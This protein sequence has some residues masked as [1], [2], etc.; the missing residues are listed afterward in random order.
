ADAANLTSFSSSFTLDAPVEDSDLDLTGVT[1]TANAKDITDGSQTG[2]GD[3]TTTIVVDAI[4]DE[5]PVVT[6]ALVPEVDESTSGSQTILLGLGFSMAD[7]GFTGSLAGGADTDGSEAVTSVTVSLSDGTLVL[8]AGYAGSASL[9]DNGGGNWTLSGWADAADLEAAV[10]ALSVTVAEGFDGTITGSISTTTQE[11]NT[12]EGAVAASG[13]E[14]DTSDNVVSDTFDFS[15]I[16]DSLPTAGNLDIAVDEDDLP[17]GNSDVATGD[18]LADP[19]PTIIMGTLN[20]DFGADS[21]GGSV[22]FA[23]LDGL[24]VVDTGSNPVT[25]GSVALVYDWNAGTNTLTALAGATPVFT[26]VVTDPSTGDFTFTLLE[27]VDHPTADTEDN[28]AIALAFTVT[29]GDGDMATGTLTVDIDDDSPNVVT[30]NSALLANDAGGDTATEQLNFFEIVG[31]DRGSDADVVFVNNAADNKL[32]GSFDGGAAE[33]LTAGGHEILLTGF[34]SASLQGFVDLNDNGLID[35]GAGSLVLQIDLNPDA[36]DESLDTYTIQ[37]FGMIDNG[38]QII[39]DDFSGIHGNNNVFFPLNSSNDPSA[40]EDLLITATVPGTSTVNTDNDDVGTGDQWLNNDDTPADGEIIRLDYV[41]NVAGDPDDINT[42]SYTQHY[43]VNDAG[44]RVHQLQGNSSISRSVLVRVYDEDDD[45]QGSDFAT[46]GAGDPAE[47]DDI[48]SARVEAGDGVFG[49]SYD[50]LVFDGV[51]NVFVDDRLTF[52]FNAD[53]SVKIDGLLTDD[54]VFVSTDDG[55]TQMEIQNVTSGGN[56]GIAVDSFVIASQQSGDPIDL[57]FDLQVTDSDGDTNSGTLDVTLLP[58]LNGQPGVVN[59]TLVSNGD[60]E[61][62]VGGLGND[63]LTGDGGADVFVFNLGV[64]DG[65]DRI[66][67][68]ASSEDRLHFTDVVDGAGDD[69][70]D[71][72][73]MIASIVNDGSGDVQVNFTNGGSVVFE[74]IAFAAQTSIADLVDTNTQV[75]VDH[76]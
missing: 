12:P 64:D 23:A 20:F 36:S 40:P 41:E 49:A 48:T 24:A 42:L 59:D 10:E 45:P 54:Q 70:Q 3:F 25:S 47:Q 35:D 22:D 31:A 69:I 38:E 50:G 57:S 68:F 74:G 19:S 62:L 71:V 56:L 17:S 55:F 8:D 16:V 44:F 5:A 37:L 18:D 14:P 72:D 39:F 76:V 65:D 61:I 1:I 58:Q 75:I 53:G 2:S 73:D 52:T 46:T 4:L 28:I 9:T 67:D 34:D 66:T 13:D 7:A 21:A 32:R 27:P 6:Q 63:T 15:L 30:A 51:A 33:V 11:A 26:V 43:V 29:D 60:A